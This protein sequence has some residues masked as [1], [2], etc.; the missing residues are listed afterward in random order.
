MLC[1][2]AAF[3][4]LQG[5]GDLILDPGLFIL[6]AG[7][8]DM[9]GRIALGIAVGVLLFFFGYAFHREKVRSTE[10]P[11]RVSRYVESGNSAEGIE[12]PFSVLVHE[13]R[14]QKIVPGFIAP[15]DDV[16]WVPEPK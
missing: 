14:I 4:P 2:P 1:I 9:A 13:T 6:V 15:V 8:V 3:Y 10:I 16:V 12:A 7:G 11:F 5:I